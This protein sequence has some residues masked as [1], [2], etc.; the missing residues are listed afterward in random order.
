MTTHESDEPA[1]LVLGG[2]YRVDSVIGR[3]GMSVVYHGTDTVMGRDVAL[4]VFNSDLA[5]ADDLER[6]AGEIRLIASLNH[7]ALVTAYDAVADEVGR[8]ALVL[9]YVTGHDLRTELAGGIVGETR[10]ALIGADI[11]AALAYI[12]DRGIVHRDLKPGNILM[13]DVSQGETATA[14]KLADFGIARLVDATHLTSAGSFLGTAGYLSPEQAAGESV[15]P[16][17]DV[18]SLGLVLL[19]CVTGTREFGGTALEAAVAR[20][21]R[22]PAV[23]AGL[24]DWTGI[25][26]RMTR[27]DPASRATAVEAAVALRALVSSSLPEPTVEVEA[28]TEAFAVPATER[29][30]EVFA[31][32]SP[33]ARTA[34]HPAP[35]VDAATR[36]FTTPSRDA[37]TEVFDATSAA[38]AA[39]PASARAPG[40]PPTAEQP[41]PSPGRPA[42]RAP[43]IVAWTI[44]AV[45]LVAAAALFAGPIVRSLDSG[46]EPI[47]YPAVDGELGSHLEQLQR[48]VAP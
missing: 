45:V 11:A 31:A 23:P 3:G 47:I 7:P 2:R 48:S 9:E 13:P 42:R 43:L 20:L 12:H 27:R 10:A 32:P 28:P 30:T 5:S 33:D 46:P 6:Q 39:A 4:K 1:G 40:S 38:P 29:A 22:D 8:L 14:A 36:V 21:S 16:P 19:E 35:A 15:G 37:A 44:V 25:L 24:G 18:Y 41:A 34:A 26:E 17:G